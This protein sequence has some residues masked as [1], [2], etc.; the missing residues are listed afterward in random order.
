MWYEVVC[1]DMCIGKEVG[2]D[3]VEVCLIDSSRV[4]WRNL[5]E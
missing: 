2:E 1:V 5:T 4:D 3:A